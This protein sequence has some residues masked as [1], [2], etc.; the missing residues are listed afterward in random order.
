[1][2]QCSKQTMASAIQG[3]ED[4]KFLGFDHLD[5]DHLILFRISD[6]ACLAEAAT[7]RQVL[8][9]LEGF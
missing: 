2:L 1:M 6:Y 5:F 3:F 7:R 9:I 8:R 4:P